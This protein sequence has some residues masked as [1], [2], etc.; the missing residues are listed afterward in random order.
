MLN[1]KHLHK[2]VDWLCKYYKT[3]VL[4]LYAANFPTIVG[5]SQATVKELLNNPKLDGKPGL[6]LAKLRDPDFD[7]HGTVDR[8]NVIHT[9]IFYLV[10]AKMNVSAFSG[11]FFTEGQLW[12][13]QRRFSLRNMRD[14]GFGRRADELESEMQDEVLN[15]IDLLKN[16]PKHEFEKVQLFIF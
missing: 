10:G 3:D 16:G 11:I 6:M 13:E 9:F 14:F 7:V 8:C 2:A 4:G 15:L 1:Y 5:N 12:F